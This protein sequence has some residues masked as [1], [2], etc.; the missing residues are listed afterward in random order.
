MA[1]TLQK[2]FSYQE[3][4]VTFSSALQVSKNSNGAG[5]ITGDYYVQGLNISPDQDP[6]HKNAP[7]QDIKGAL[8]GSGVNFEFTVGRHGTT[9][10]ANWWNS[11]ISSTQ[12]TF[13]HSAT[14]LNFAFLGTLTLRYQ[15][16]ANSQKGPE[17]F[18]TAT[19]FNVGIAQGQSGSDN[20]WWFGAKNAAL[21]DTSLQNSIKLQGVDSNGKATTWTFS[22]GTPNGTP[23]N[24][25]DS[26][27]YV[28]QIQY[29]LDGFHQTLINPA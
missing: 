4:T 21:G 12:N 3:N 18:I 28:H 2:R 11:Q 22:R 27:I 16:P 29:T 13:Q 20:N 6:S 8:S 1:P 23:V 7:G 14:N 9:D 15:L 24:N 17:S 10:V 26:T 5:L 19:F 25:N